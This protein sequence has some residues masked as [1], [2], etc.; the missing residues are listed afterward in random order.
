MLTYILFDQDLPC[1]SLL[2]PALRISLESS[3]SDWP[4]L[5]EEASEP[6]S[7]ILPTLVFIDHYRALSAMAA[8]SIRYPISGKTVEGQIK[9]FMFDLPEGFYELEDQQ[10]R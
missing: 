4:L 8:L 5:Y 10:K 6:A 7:T 2:L 9:T 1:N 3:G